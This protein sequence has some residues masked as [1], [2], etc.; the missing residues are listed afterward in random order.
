MRNKKN[1]LGESGRN[2]GTMS[3]VELDHSNSIAEGV[4]G[5]SHRR[6]GLAQVALLQQ[7]TVVTQKKAVF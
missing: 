2:K 5:G 4:F 6:R 1:L 7:S 3:L